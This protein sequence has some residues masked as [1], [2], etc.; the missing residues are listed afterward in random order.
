MAAGGRS[1]D[2]STDGSALLPPEESVKSLVRRVLVTV[3]AASLLTAA[4][5]AWADATRSILIALVNGAC[6][7]ALLAALRKI[8]AGAAILGATLVLL[9]ATLTAMAMGRGVH[10]IAIV[11]LPAAVFIA[12]L[13]LS[14]RQYAAMASVAVVGSTVIAILQHAGLAGPDDPR[15]LGVLDL[16]LAPTLLTAASVVN[17]FLV[18]AFRTSLLR[19]AMREHDYHEI[20]NATE[21]AIFVIDPQ[22]GRLVDA[23][24]TA[25]GMF[26]YERD[27][28]LVRTIADLSAREAS[29]SQEVA[30]QVMARVVDEGPQVLEWHARRSDGREFWVEVTARRARIA[31]RERLLVVARDIEERRRMEAELRQA[32]KLQAVGLLAGNVAHDFNNQLTGLVGYAELLR[33][34]A[35]DPDAVR[36]YADGILTAA[37]RAKSSTA[38][39]LTFARRAPQARGPVDLHALTR[40][41]VDLLRRSLGPQVQV[42]TD[43]RA[44]RPTTPG[45]AAQLQSALLNLA[46]NARDAM[47]LGGQLTFCTRDVEIS[48]GAPS[49]EAGGLPP[50]AYVEL[51]VA[52]TGHGMDAATRARIFEPFFT[53]RATGTG[54]GLPAV[55]AAVEAH[56]GRIAVESAPGKGSVFRLWFPAQ[57]WAAEAPGEE[58]A[59]GAIRLPGLR[60]LMAEDDP[61][62]ADAT[63]EMLESLGCRVTAVA[64]GRAAVERYG[65]DPGGFDVILLDLLM[66]RLGGAEALLE[67]LRV[68]PEAVVVL[69]SGFDPQA[70]VDRLLR[71]GAAAFL[72]K[73]FHSA[74][75]AAVLRR[76]TQAQR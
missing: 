66:P 50:G 43:L 63:R 10:D 41:V 4:V 32:E 47:P 56:G 57:P 22:D 37:S 64:D 62:A 72:R 28:I 31:E 46:L 39:L 45:D 29:F 12:G 5:S 21:E 69:M 34:K 55:S 49:G 8:G 18:G 42:L 59:R 19:A 76:A 61:V 13:V 73:P 23:N 26:G 58:A 67:I 70:D 74:D 17:A 9:G 7:A 6:T 68:R 48:P 65:A 20:F 36:R 44:Q 11:L 24:A 40:E 71:S 53:T 35:H 52:D 15:R 27:Q 2:V 33:S 54:I 16:V 75:L 30:N 60:V 1:G 3:I 25:T 14:R 51:V 38:R